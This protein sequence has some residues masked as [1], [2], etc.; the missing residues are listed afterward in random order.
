[1][2]KKLTGNALSKLEAGRDIWQEVLDG[3]NEIKAGGGKHFSA[4]PVSPIVRTRLK[5]AGCPAAPRKL[6]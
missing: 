3:V 4:E 6:C 2:T 5:A 1:M